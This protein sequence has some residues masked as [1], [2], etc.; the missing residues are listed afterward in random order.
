VSVHLIFELIIEVVSLEA[1]VESLL[2]GLQFG[3]SAREGIAIVLNQV[4]NLG[5]TPLLRGWACRI[6]EHYGLGTAILNWTFA[7]LDD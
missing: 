2:A 6:L 3:T 1:K 4:C 5:S 7:Y